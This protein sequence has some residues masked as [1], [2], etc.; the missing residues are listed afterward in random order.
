MSFMARKQQHGMALVVSL[1]L[2]VALTLVAVTS[3]KGT[4][5]ELKMS[6]NQV[7]RSEAFE[8]SEGPRLLVSELI[9]AHAFARGWPK[10]Q[11]GDI[12]D[13][14]FDQ[15]LPTGLVLQ[16]DGSS[17]LKQWYL[18]NDDCKKEPCPFKPNSLEKDAAYAR[19]VA[20]S[21]TSKFEIKT[22]IGVFKVRTDLAPGAGAAMV[23]GYEGTG[24]AA[25]A[26]G[27][28]VFFF[29]RS[30]G[31]DASNA[32]SAVTAASYRHVIRN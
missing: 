21:G 9:D 14:L 8:S 28:N 32:A 19:N 18:N 7:M 10:S 15:P 2:L 22:D 5:L 23:S 20:A 26:G 16:K 25:A 27:G 24:K 3:L 31:K 1:V 12:P 29:V 11:G 4:G 30:E 17:Q 13:D 6:A